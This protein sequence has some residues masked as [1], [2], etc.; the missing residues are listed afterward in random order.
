MAMMGYFDTW[1]GFFGLVVGFVM[2]AWFGWRP[3]RSAAAGYAC[4][5]VLVVLINVMAPEPPACLQNSKG[6]DILRAYKLC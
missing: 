2:A 4:G 6:I 3:L 5:V 1:L